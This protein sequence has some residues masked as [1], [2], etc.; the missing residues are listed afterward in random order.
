MGVVTLS[1]DAKVDALVTPFMK[2]EMVAPGTYWDIC[3]D[4]NIN[5]RCGKLFI[6]I[7]LINLEYL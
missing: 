1:R 4:L 2:G 6:A 7:D 3:I 5:I